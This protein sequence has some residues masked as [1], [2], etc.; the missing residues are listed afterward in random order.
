MAIWCRSR[1]LPNVSDDEIKRRV[2]EF[3][4]G[5]ARQLATEKYGVKYYDDSIDHAG[6]DC[7]MKLAELENFD[8]G[9]LGIKA[10]IILELRKKLP[11]GQNV[12]LIIITRY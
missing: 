1:F 11:P 5:T 10:R 9:R 7:G 2:S 12:R 8:F 4:W 3:T 6:S